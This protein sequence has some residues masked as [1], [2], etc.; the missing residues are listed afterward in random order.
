[1]NKLKLSQSIQQKAYRLVRWQFIG[2]V[3]L[4][5]SIAIASSTKIGLSVFA[6]G[7]AYALPNLFFVWGVFRYAGANEMQ[8]FLI[9][10]FLGEIF[11]IILSGIIF[12]L[13]VNYL[14]VSLISVLIGLAGAMI[15]FWIACFWQF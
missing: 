3:I 15:I 6:G 11:K 7:L 5:V 12:I 13:V 2:I 8:R 1:M 4:A 14:P 9:A 10:F